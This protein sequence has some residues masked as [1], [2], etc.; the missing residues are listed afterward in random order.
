M[1]AE[2]RLIQGCGDPFPPLP[3]TTSQGP[4]IFPFSVSCLVYPPLH[5][6]V[7]V[8]ITVPHN[9]HW[10]IH[11]HT[12]FFLDKAR[13]LALKH[14]IALAYLDLDLDLFAPSRGLSALT[15]Q[16]SLSLSPPPKKPHNP[17][18]T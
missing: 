18:T 8:G 5:K 1:Y 15:P 17:L 11:A 13:L 3:P 4:T 12:R 10:H 2:L 7:T 9:P 14:A 6:H 16:S